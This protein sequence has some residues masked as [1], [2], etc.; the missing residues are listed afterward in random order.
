M[1]RRRGLWR[2]FGWR[3]A[4]PHFSF[5]ALFWCFP[6]S[7]HAVG[8]HDGGAV[9]HG[10]GD[11]RAR[12]D[13]HL[14]PDLDV[15]AQHRAARAEDA[16]GPDARMPLRFRIGHRLARG[17]QRDA[18][19]QVAVAP[20]LRGRADHHAGGM[21]EHAPLAEFRPWVDVGAPLFGDLG[22][23]QQSRGP[24]RSRPSSV[25]GAGLPEGVRDAVDGEGVEALEE[26]ERLEKRPARRVRDGHLGQVGHQ[27]AQPA[28]RRVNL[29]RRLPKRRLP[30]IFPL[31]RRLACRR[32]PATAL[33]VVPRLAATATRARRCRR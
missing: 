5:G 28:R 18:V 13:R 19:K 20:D 30:P 22:L 16:P 6:R 9:G 10:L 25:G 26:Q 11:H 15:A 7:H 31:T 21:V 29:A 2:R 14:V 24:P 33:V 32:A 23:Q 17:A 4:R 3:G 27:C 12:P 1:T 8:P